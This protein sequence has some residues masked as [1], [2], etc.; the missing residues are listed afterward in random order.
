MAFQAAD[1]A[2]WNL[3]AS[4][5]RRPLLPFKYQ[6]LGDMMA[7][8]TVDAAVAFPLDL[9]VDGSHLTLH[10][11]HPCVVSR[12]SRLP[13]AA[14]L[15][16]GDNFL[17]IER[18]PAWYRKIGRL[19]GGEAVRMDYR[20]GGQRAAE[21]GVRV[22]ATDAGPG[23][24]GWL[25]HGVAPA[26]GPVGHQHRQAAGPVG[27]LGLRDAGG[28][29][30][31]RDSGHCPRARRCVKNSISDKK[32]QGQG[33]GQPHLTHA[34]N[35]YGYYHALP[36]LDGLIASPCASVAVGAACEMPCTLSTTRL[37]AAIQSR[38]SAS[39]LHVR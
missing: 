34:I 18:M 33:Q 31:W 12:Q 19:S 32:I 4:I 14:S 25:G 26:G 8:G 5:N 37:S 3:W 36:L 16:D 9:T 30:R 7:L 21:S 39:L 2:G 38:M 15:S 29:K 28:A 35:L 24:K 13:H 6:H 22:P 23:G 17:R 1:Y 10:L 11:R 27:G 20:N